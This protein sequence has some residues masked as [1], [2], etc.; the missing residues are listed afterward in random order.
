MVKD[1]RAH[2]IGEQGAV[3]GLVRFGEST[4]FPDELGRK[5]NSRSA[6]RPLR[7][8]GERAVA[9]HPIRRCPGLT[10]LPGTWRLGLGRNRPAA[11]GQPPAPEPMPATPAHVPR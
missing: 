10:D 2:V 6:A 5:G 9:S 3:T 1:L 11:G 4:K 7:R 8:A